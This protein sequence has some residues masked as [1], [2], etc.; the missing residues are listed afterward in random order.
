MSQNRVVLKLDT[1]ISEL[2][3]KSD[4]QVNYQTIL[5]QNP[6]SCLNCQKI[7]NINFLLRFLIFSEAFIVY[8]LL[9]N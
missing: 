2:H 3:V 4:F 1:I 9:N 7:Q 5:R 8:T 6:P